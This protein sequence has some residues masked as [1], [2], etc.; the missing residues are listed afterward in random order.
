MQSCWFQKHEEFIDSQ[1]A[2]EFPE[3]CWLFWDSGLWPTVRAHRLWN[4]VYTQAT[5]LG[6][7]QSL[8]KSFIGRLS[9]KQLWIFAFVFYDP[10]W[11]YTLMI[12][13][14]IVF[15]VTQKTH[16]HTPSQPHSQTPT[17]PNATSDLVLFVMCVKQRNGTLT[18]FPAGLKRIKIL[19][20]NSRLILKDL[21]QLAS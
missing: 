5:S 10:C 15:T 12:Y 9:R 3:I 8:L 18:P 21:G 20:T 14:I 6:L 7:F 2:L 16:T 17:S 13:I 4:T 11:F 1:C 19:C